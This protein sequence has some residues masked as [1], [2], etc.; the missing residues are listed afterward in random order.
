M[1]QIVRYDSNHQRL[2]TGEYEKNGFYEYRYTVF[3]HSFSFYSKTLEGLRVIEETVDSQNNTFQKSLIHRSMT[4]ND[5]F[6]LWKS[7]KRGIRDSTF[8]NYVWMYDS[9]VREALG[10]LYIVSL[11]KTDIKRFYNYLA[12]ERRLMLGTIDRVHGVL[13]Q[14]LQLAVDDDLIPHNPADNA[15]RELMRARNFD[16][17]KPLALS[18]AEQDL[19][20]R[21]LSNSPTFSRWIPIITV[22]LG[23]GMRVG[24]LTGLRWCDVDKENKYIDVN[25]TLVYYDKGDHHCSFAINDTK[26]PSSKRIIP[27]TDTV[28]RAFLQEREWQKT[29][30]ICCLA[31]VDGYTDFVFLNRFGMLLQQGVLNK[32]FRRIV[33]DCNDQEYLKAESPPV[34]LPQFSCHSLRHTFATNL[35]S[36]PNISIKAVQYLLGHA[37][38]STTL[39]IYCHCT[40]EILEQALSA[41]EDHKE[42][43]IVASLQA[44]NTT[45]GTIPPEMYCSEG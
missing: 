36:N 3:G 37:D 9:Y 38:V 42:S 33:R 13:H 18:K 7:L 17:K 6:M 30:G 12:D 22:F 25:H 29:Q 45:Q 44:Y 35:V 27:M 28:K 11:K 24:E 43:S 31:E 1:K 8:Q 10:R 23:T 16:Q 19:L 21:F 26:T 32:A 39:N 4:L 40:K 34:L 14:V 15:M 5:L 41:M 20:L 2:K